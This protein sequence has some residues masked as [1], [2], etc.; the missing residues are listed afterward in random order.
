MNVLQSNELNEMLTFYGYRGRIKMLT[1]CNVEA[2]LV[3]SAL[4]AKDST[5][6]GQGQLGQIG[7]PTKG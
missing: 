6:T 5:K 7:V 3:L 4:I 2:S 1:L